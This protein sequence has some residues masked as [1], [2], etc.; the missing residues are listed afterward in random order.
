METCATC[1]YF[2]T[3]KAADDK[4]GFCSNEQITSGSGGNPVTGK[5][6]VTYG[7]FD[8]Y[9]DYMNISPNFGCILHKAKGVA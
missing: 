1:D 9:G 7:G 2:R 4:G 8:G 5:I 6:L 3:Y